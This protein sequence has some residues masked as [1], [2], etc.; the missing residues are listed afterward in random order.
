MSAP[1][2][3]NKFNPVWI[4]GK[5]N[6]LLAYKKGIIPANWDHLDNQEW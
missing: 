5:K 4:S 2:S 3:G 6:C 1:L